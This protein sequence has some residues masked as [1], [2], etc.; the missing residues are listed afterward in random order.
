M[1]KTDVT[2]TRHILPFDNLSGDDFER[3]CYWVVEKSS[4][5]DSVEHYGMTGDKKRDIIGYKHSAAGKREQWYFQ[6]KRY[7]KISFSSFRDE[8]DVIKKHSD[9][10]KDFKP[11]TIVFV[12]GCRVSPSCKDSGQLAESDSIKTDEVNKEIDEAVKFIHANNIEEAKNRLYLVLGKIKDKQ[13]EHANE[14]A[15]TYN[16]LGVYFNRLRW[17]GGDFDKAEEYFS[18]A[19]KANFDFKKA[20]ANLASVFLNRGGKDNFK[21]AY[22][23]ALPLWVDSDK[24]EPS[25]PTPLRT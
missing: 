7:K 12:T 2:S 24:K 10:D 15:R 17:E 13:G 21:K 3:L 4:E 25:T 19:L 22:D 8:L 16:N 5:F 6:S 20:K 11:D 1:K 23:I 9:D 14:L 18:L